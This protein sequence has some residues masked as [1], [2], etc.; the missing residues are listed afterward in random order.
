MRHRHYGS[1]RRITKS[2][3]RVV[4]VGK[5]HVRENDILVRLARITIHARQEKV[6]PTADEMPIRSQRLGLNVLD[7]KHS[8]VR[9]LAIAAVPT[10]ASHKV[11][12]CVLKIVKV[13]GKWGGATSKRTHTKRRSL[14]RASSPE[15]PGK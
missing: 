1:V 8:V 14:K 6:F 5:K 12:L 13:S 3:K 11:G 4:A 15:T 7:C 2:C 9:P 10:H